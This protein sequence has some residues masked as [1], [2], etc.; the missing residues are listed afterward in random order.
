[1]TPDE[2]AL[3]DL[4]ERY[5]NALDRLDFD[6]LGACF[7]EDATAVYLGGDWRMDG[8]EAIVERLEA[9]RSF[10]STLHAPATMSFAVAV[11]EATGEVFAVANVAVSEDGV[12]R[13]MVR[14]LR[15]RDRYALGDGG[16]RIAHRA[17]DPLWQY[18]VA[19]ISPSIPAQ[20]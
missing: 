20:R 10:D 14:G 4:N 16:W 11:A 12:Q 2:Q 13:L 19:T 3:R 9:I 1:M 6:A 7:T 5:F 18:D 15:Y 17:Q 8:R